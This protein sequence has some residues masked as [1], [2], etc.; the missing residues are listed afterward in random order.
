MAPRLKPC[1]CARPPAL[2][3]P[4]PAAQAREG[5]DMC[6]KGGGTGLAW[7]SCSPSTQA[8]GVTSV[9]CWAGPGPTHLRPEAPVPC[10]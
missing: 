1:A 4:C 5:R 9:G 6:T 8:G 3:E 7:G 10:S 2:R